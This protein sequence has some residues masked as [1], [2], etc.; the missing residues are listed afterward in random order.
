[1]LHVEVEAFIS[2]PIGA[3]QRPNAVPASCSARLH[4]DTPRQY[5][6]RAWVQLMDQR[7]NPSR[8]ENV[9][10]LPPKENDDRARQ[11]NQKRT[12]PA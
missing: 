12:A 8:L 11:E 7:L 3:F 6:A 9:G 5:S 2:P 4:H 1:M 10:V